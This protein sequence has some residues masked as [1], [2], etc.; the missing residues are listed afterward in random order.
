MS[1]GWR[2]WLGRARRIF[3][4]VL[5]KFLADNGLFLASALAFNL[6]LYF[7]PL[8][9]LM[10]SLLGYTVLDSERAMNEVQSVLRAFL[11]RSQEALAENLA[12]VVADR[13]LLGFAGFVCF[14][15][16]STFLF[17][18]V[19]T[20][21]NRVFQVKHERTLVKGIGIDLL[22]M[23]FTAILLLVAVAA[24]W[25]LTVTDAFAERYPSWSG[26]VQPGLVA[27][28][29]TF[30]VAVTACLLYVLYRFAPAATISSRALMIASMTGTLLFQFAK[31]GFGW[32]VVIAQQNVELYGALAGLIF[33][34][35]WLY[36]ASV[37]FIIG[38]EVG[39]AY[40][41]ERAEVDLNSNGA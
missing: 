7:I 41:R 2:Q 29:K 33:L 25:F 9:L 30:G 37:V 4:A 13:G 21:L 1:K 26:F 19:R 18:S 35:V 32:Y 5:Q 12:A 22:M 11:P 6:L 31:W 14:L 20:V 27:F 17:G 36:Y 16:F 24:T 15:I 23:G 10:V 38:A 8:S 34:F 28:S 40:D 3:Q 39:W